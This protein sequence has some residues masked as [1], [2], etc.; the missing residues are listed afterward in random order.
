MCDVLETVTS[1]GLFKIFSQIFSLFSTVYE[2]QLAKHLKKCNSREK[3]KPVSVGNVW[4]VMFIYIYYIALW[5]A[6]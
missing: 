6:G 2:D 3:P 5:G 1:Q 4:Y